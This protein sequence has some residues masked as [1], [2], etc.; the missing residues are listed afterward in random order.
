MPWKVLGIDSHLYGEEMQTVLRLSR[1][2]P[3][4]DAKIEPGMTRD[5]IAD[6]IN[7]A[8]IEILEKVCA[9][10]EK[11]AK[12]TSIER[13]LVDAGEKF[14]TEPP[15]SST[16]GGRLAGIDDERQP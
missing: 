3:F 13:L 1:S 16:L 10:L 8:G 2:A 7:K 14:N 15:A 12:L 11:L 9:D 6:A 5:S 4:E